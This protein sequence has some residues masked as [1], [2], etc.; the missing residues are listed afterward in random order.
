MAGLNASPG[1]SPYCSTKFGI[2]G[3]VKTDAID[4]G[5]QGIRVN[6]VCPGFTDTP[7]LHAISTAD[8]RVALS[9]MIPL[10]RLG[11]AED[12]GRTFAFLCSEEAG[13]VSGASYLCDGGAMVFRRG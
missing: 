7:A 13:Y 3:L 5:P 4:C 11:E 12:V 10:Q 1:A 8:Q 2:I 6:A 9:K